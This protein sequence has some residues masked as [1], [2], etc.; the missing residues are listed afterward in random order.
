M[1]S[2]YYRLKAEFT[3]AREYYEDALKIYVDVLE[4]EKD[5]GYNAEKHK[6]TSVSTGGKISFKHRGSI[7]KEIALTHRRIGL[8]Y[9]EENTWVLAF[10]SLLKS[11]EMY[12]SV[13]CGLAADSLEL[14][15]TL[16]EAAH[17]AIRLPASVEGGGLEN[18]VGML[19]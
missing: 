5:Q 18:A 15:S 3:S 4:H 10:A 2:L 8:A 7:Q 11:I 16:Y 9:K 12:K 17:V 1:F 6:I 14:A 13:Q 19:R